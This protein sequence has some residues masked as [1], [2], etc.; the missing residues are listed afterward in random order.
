[1]ITTPA[2]AGEPAYLGWSKAWKPLLWKSCINAEG[3][4]PEAVCF[5]WGCIPVW[6]RT[7]ICPRGL[8]Q[9][10]SAQKPELK[11]IFEGLQVYYLQVQ[12]GT[13]LQGQEEAE[14]CGLENSRSAL[15]NDFNE[16]IHCLNANIVA[17]MISE[18]I[19]IGL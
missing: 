15:V 17:E 10:D 12:T 19:F 7:L 6:R 18:A 14:L 11:V 2:R 13:L 9:S 1:M 3:E 5:R 4:P 16:Y 8:R